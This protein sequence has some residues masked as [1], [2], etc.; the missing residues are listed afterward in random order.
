METHITWQRDF[1]T[2]FNFVLLRLTLKYP[3]RDSTENDLNEKLAINTYKSIF[4]S[5]K[6]SFIE[7]KTRTRSSKAKNIFSRNVR[8][9]LRLK[10]FKKNLRKRC[11]WCR[12]RHLTWWRH[13]KLRLGRRCLVDLVRYY[14]G[15]W[16]LVGLLCCVVDYFSVLWKCLNAVILCGTVYI[17]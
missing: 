3:R 14:L 8:L 12:D 5:R 17:I 13:R 1:E 9:L 7:K 10:T 16:W 11:L 6:V 2:D 15:E 4:D